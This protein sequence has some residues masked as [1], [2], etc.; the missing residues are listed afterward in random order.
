MADVAKAAN[1]SVSA[2]SLA[3]RNSPLISPQ[4]RARIQ[5]AASRLG[6]VPDPH[7]ARLMGYLR[8]PSAAKR[9]G[10]L[11]YLTAFDPP[12]AWRSVPVWRRYFSGAQR[13]A[14]EL[15]Y[16]MEEFS[17][18]APGLTSKRIGRVLQA[19]GISG[20]IVAPLPEGTH[21][22]D[23]QWEP[24]CAVAIG[25]SLWSPRQHAI[26]HH[27][28]ASMVTALQAVRAR[29]YRRIALVLE[30]NHD[31][32]VQHHW[33]AAFLAEQRRTGAR[34]SL[35][36]DQLDRSAAFVAWF[37]RHRPDV[38]LGDNLV[39]ARIL[40]AAGYRIPRDCAFVVL[41]LAGHERGFAGINQLS[42]AIGVSAVS[43]LV[44]ALRQNDFGVPDLPEVTLVPGQW[45]DGAS[46][47]Q[48]GTA[49]E[50]VVP[51]PLDPSLKRLR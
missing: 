17:M 21:E 50:R 44:G 40:D 38:I 30:P 4:T 47:P 20:V 12:D 25:L 51:A 43:R 6:Y 1:V 8:Q 16:S 22:L 15:G 11:A 2:V 48:K 7:V 13:R 28:L 5:S 36:F 41:N 3:L 29:G 18:R 32:R 26:V 39:A 31:L 24:F 35:I 33:S 23:L 42:E 10:T 19:R 14:A 49:K 27:H 9:A 46:L 34:G 37:R 45:V